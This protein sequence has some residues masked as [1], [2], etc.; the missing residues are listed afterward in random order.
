[1]MDSASTAVGH[2]NIPFQDVARNLDT[3]LAEPDPWRPL[4]DACERLC[5]H[6]PKS[7]LDMQQVGKLWNGRRDVELQLL[8]YAVQDFEFLRYFPGL[9]RLNVQV[10][11]IKSI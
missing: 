1:M 6:K 4:H 7:D 11:I 2:R 8:G 3:E 9:T 5:I 10:P